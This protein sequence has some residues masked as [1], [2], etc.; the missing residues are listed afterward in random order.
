LDFLTVNFFYRARLSALD[1]TTATTAWNEERARELIL[2]KRRVMVDEIAKQLNICVG[3]AHSVV[4]F[5]KPCARW[6]PKEMMDEPKRMRLDI[7]SCHLAPYRKEGD[8]FL[9]HIITGDET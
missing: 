6:V 9:Q 1:P 3:S 2:Q 5:L 8:N 4:Q 7:C